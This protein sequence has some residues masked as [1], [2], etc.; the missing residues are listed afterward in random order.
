[1]SNTSNQPLKVS[2]TTF[3]KDPIDAFEIMVP[4]SKEK[5]KASSA[6]KLRSKITNQS[7]SAPF[8]KEKS[9]SII[10]KHLDRIISVHNTFSNDKRNSESSI[11]KPKTRPQSS[12]LRKGVTYK[13]INKVNKKQ[14]DLKQMILCENCKEKQTSASKCICGSED[15]ILNFQIEIRP[16]LNTDKF[17]LLLGKKEF[18]VN[19]AEPVDLNIKLEKGERKSVKLIKSPDLVLKEDLMLD[20]MHV[21]TP[22]FHGISEKMMDIEH[23]KQFSNVNE[24]EVSFAEGHEEFDGIFKE[25]QELNEILT[26]VQSGKGR[27]KDFSHKFD[28]IMEKIQELSS[29]NVKEHL[30]GIRKIVNN[31]FDLMICK[32]NDPR[33]LHKKLDLRLASKSN[34]INGLIQGNNKLY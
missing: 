33:L 4:S 19:A 1:M 16:I 11:Q 34:T 32:E 22:S 6:S 2:R 12:K 30:E 7:P 21:N 17:Q 18:V 15:K 29:E 8:Q 20:S 3:L 27:I 13:I 23:F 14:F 25:I 9:S 26:S 5:R 31:Y 10:Q 24:F 28:E